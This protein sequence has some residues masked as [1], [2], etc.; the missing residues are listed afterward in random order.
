VIE[1]VLLL[2]GSQ[3]KYVAQIAKNFDDGT[4]RD[5]PLANYTFFS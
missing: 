4:R 3:P 2:E 1:P 5:R